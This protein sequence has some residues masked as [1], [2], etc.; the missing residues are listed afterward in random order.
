MFTPEQAAALSG[1]PSLLQRRVD[2]AVRAIDAGIPSFEEEVWRYS[3]IDELNL[4]N[5]HLGGEAGAMSSGLVD[6]V[7]ATAAAT[8]QVSNGVL[9]SI[10]INNA[11]VSIH[12]ADELEDGAAIGSVMT[13]AV[14]MFADMNLAFTT[15]PIVIDIPAGK[16]IAEPIVVSSY[17][18]IDGLAWFPRLVVRVGENAECTIVE[19]HSSA[20]V[21][22]LVV[23]ITEMRVDQAARARQLTVQELGP[24]VWQL[25]SMLGDIHRDAHLEV[26]Q[27]A[28]GGGYARMRMDTRMV[29]KGANGDINAVYFGRGDASHDFRTFQTHIA[30]HTNSKLLFKGAVDD[31]SRAI[32]TG[33]IRIEKEASAVTAFQT[34]RNLKLS[35]DAWAESVPNLEIENNDVKCS[36]ASAVGPIDAD[37]QFYL[38][39][40]GVPAD[41]AETLVVRGFFS[42]VLEQLP[43]PAIAAATRV[44]LNELLADAGIDD[45]RVGAR[46]EVSA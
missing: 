6:D 17:T 11:D 46:E 29:G 33:L 2:A 8:V 31:Q 27:V 15:A 5:Y 13:E 40:R 4:S 25:G 37:Q 44:R 23:P 7:L 42:E 38:E 28:L 35:D 36:H 34:N 39:S 21:S 45:V 10:D 26:S 14:D 24:R 18:D 20:D 16:V 41:V 30:P 12:R 1:S 9:V 19:H 32:Y 22:A 43:V 3:P